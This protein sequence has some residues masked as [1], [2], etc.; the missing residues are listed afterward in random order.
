MEKIRSNCII[1]SSAYSVPKSRV[2]YIDSMTRNDPEVGDLI[3]GEIV[4]LGHHAFLAPE[5]DAQ[6]LRL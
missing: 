5:L 1:P 3:M 6:Q 2:R 4:E